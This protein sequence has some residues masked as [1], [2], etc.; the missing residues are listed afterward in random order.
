MFGDFFYE[1]INIKKFFCF[2]FISYLC[3][4]DKSF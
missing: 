3:T 4:H 1:K 2:I